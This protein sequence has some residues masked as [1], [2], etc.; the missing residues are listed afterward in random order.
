MARKERWEWEDQLAY[1][2]LT[3]P[4]EVV[5]DACRVLEKHG[6]HI[7]KEVKSKLWYKYC[8]MLINLIV[9]QAL[10]EWGCFN[11]HLIYLDREGS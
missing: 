10:T 6:Y 9:A 2:L 1:V 5:Q 8:I 4:A 11:V 3:K 7:K